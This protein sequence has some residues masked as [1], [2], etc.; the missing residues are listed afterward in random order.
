MEHPMGRRFVFARRA[1]RALLFAVVAIPLPLVAQN[2]RQQTKQD[3]PAWYTADRAILAKESYTQ[4]P[5]EIAR[6]VTAPR[7]LNVALG[8]LSP[9]RKYFITERGGGMPGVAVFGKP[10]LFLGGL[11]VDPK[12]NRTRA[13][14][15]GT[16][17]GLQIVDATTKTSMAIETPK[18]ATVSGPSWPPD[19]KQLA[20]LAHF[21]SGSHVFVADVATGKSVRLTKTPLL[22]TLVTTISWVPDGSGVLAVL[23]PD[24]RG[25][26]PKRPEVTVGPQVRLWMDGVKSPQRNLWSLLE[27]PYDGELL[28]YYATG[29][30]AILDVKTHTAKKLGVP[31]MI[32]TVEASS[33]GRYFLVTT[34]QEP[35]SYA[36]FCLKKNT[37]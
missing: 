26:E 13:L 2:T 9:D 18:G 32:Q 36:V 19:G 12:A 1:V 5:S 7:H 6:L 23:L 11:A 15:T 3:A 10:H 21:D 14:T 34:M 28:K 27:E 37:T 24:N 33:D 30:L 22:A 4:P 25:P 31:A 16:V 8:Q 17:A 35:I 20:D 29:Q